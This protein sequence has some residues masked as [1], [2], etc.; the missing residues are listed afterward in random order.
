MSSSQRP[1]NI[2]FI[3]SDQHR[4][5]YLGASGAGFMRTPNLDALAARGVRFTQCCT[6]AP[7]CTPARVGLATGLQPARL[8]SL[9]NRSYLPRSATTYYQRLR[10]A[11]YRV[12]CVGKLDLAKPDKYNGRCGDRPCVFG[13]GFT[14]PEE[15]EGKMH[16]GANPTPQGPYGLLLQ[17]KGLYAKF[18]EDYAA[19]SAR[20]WRIGASHDSVLPTEY[21]ADSYIGRRSAEWIESIPDDFP[22]HLFVSFVGPHDP[23]D[24]PTEYA[25]RYRDAAVPEP[26][27]D[28]MT[29][30]PRWVAGRREP[31]TAEQVAE[32][33]RQYCASTELIDAEVGRILDALERRG[34]A[35]NTF[36]IYSSDHGEMLGDH[37]LYH[38]SCAYEAAL[39]VPLICAGPGI[40]AGGTS[41][42]LVEL[43]DVNPTICE[44]AGLPPQERIDARSIG[45]VLRGESESHRSETVSA[46][47]GFRCVRSDRWKYIENYNDVDELY[48]LAEDPCELRSL[49]ADQPKRCREMRAL[50]V[51]RY[52]EGQWRR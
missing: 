32:T 49:A 37:G 41:D 22:W 6:N 9:D 52:E 17:E 26:V 45:A 44:L 1:P 35:G 2:L 51:R 27:S 21:F 30:K 8:G 40:A 20:G 13:W 4:H 5:D 12:G 38:K 7:V 46:L 24:P 18:H 28:E 36:V 50:M 43:I 25:D 15:V 48:D 31:G 16:A 29:G 11:G 10:D 23:F 47:R 3:S 19:R 34:M 42:A 39:R 14:H 33:R